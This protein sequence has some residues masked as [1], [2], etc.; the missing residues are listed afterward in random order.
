[1]NGDNAR[2]TK[3]ERQVLDALK[4]QLRA[5][6]RL[7]EN[8][9]FTDERGGD[10][11]IDALLLLP[12]F[13]A[14]VI[15]IKGGLVEYTGGEWVT[16]TTTSRRRIR[17][18][19]QGRNGKH[20]LRTF[21]SRQDSWQH[22]LVRTEW[23]IAMPFTKVTGDMGPE[24]LREILIGSD[25]VATALDQVRSRLASVQDGDA[26]LN[27][28][29]VEQAMSLL[30]SQTGAARRSQT[31]HVVQLTV[32]GLVCAIVAAGFFT[33]AVAAGHTWATWLAAIAGGAV[34]G[35]IG[36]F[37][38]LRYQHFSRD[39]AVAGT[40]AFL[41]GW[42][43]GAPI[44]NAAPIKTLRGCQPSYSGCLPIVDD[45]DCAEIVGM[46]E[47]TGEDVYRLDRDQDGIGC[48]WN[49]KPKSQ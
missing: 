28:V 2:Q 30:K 46:V 38:R 10:V 3:S 31:G 12:G 27:V 19:E 22:G 14:A 47:V 24:G 4:S 6:E 39:L 1:M 49:E 34:V 18:T 44:A 9:R 21:L 35:L 32:Y 8:I 15:E 40:I 41:I 48:E 43:L 29:Q 25:D 11:E 20:A 13:G 5:G 7:L 45:L 37:V 33:A 42:I 26:V 17:P 16:T 23:F 36:N